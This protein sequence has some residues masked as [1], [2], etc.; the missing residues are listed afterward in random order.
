MKVYLYGM[1]LQARD[2]KN[3]FS[4]GYLRDLYLEEMT[5]DMRDEYFN[6]LVYKCKLP[7]FIV[8]KFDYEFIAERVMDFDKESVNF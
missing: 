1:K 8:K 4:M 2:N 7:T 3:Y 5:C 6:V